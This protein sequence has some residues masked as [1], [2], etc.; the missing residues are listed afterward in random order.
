VGR[1]AFREALDKGAFLCEALAGELA[2]HVWGE[3]RV[4]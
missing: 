3:L 4:E 1:Q 2:V